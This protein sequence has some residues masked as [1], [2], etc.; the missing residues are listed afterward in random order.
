MKNKSKFKLEEISLKALVRA[1]HVGNGAQINLVIRGQVK[2]HKSLFQ[3][4]SNKTLLNEK[5]FRKD[6]I[7]SY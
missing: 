5:S 4:K 3:Q 2:G 6:D 7:T 1:K